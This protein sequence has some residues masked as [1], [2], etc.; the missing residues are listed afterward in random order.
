MDDTTDFSDRADLAS[1]QLGME[2]QS[3]VVTTRRLGEIAAGWSDSDGGRVLAEM[4][5]RLVESSGCV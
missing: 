3:G 5:Q 4:W 1:T 2:M